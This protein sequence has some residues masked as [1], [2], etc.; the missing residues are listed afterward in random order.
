MERI[1]VKK[2]ASVTYTASVQTGKKQGSRLAPPIIK[3]VLAIMCCM[4]AYFTFLTAV[5]LGISLTRTAAV[6]ISVCVLC[7][8]AFSLRGKYLAA[9]SVPVLSALLIWTYF[10]RYE[11]CAGLF[12]TVN[13]YASMIHSDYAETPFMYITEPELAESHMQIFMYFITMVSSAAA[14]YSAQRLNSAEVMLLSVFTPVFLTL[15]YGMEPNNIAVF[16]F[17]AGWTAM[18]ALEANFPGKDGEECRKSS[19]AFCGLYTG[20]ACAVCIA[21]VLLAYKSF[22]YKRPEPLNVLYD[23]AVAFLYG[24]GAQETLDK[25]VSDVKRIVVTTGATDHGKLGELDEISFDGRTMLEVTLPKSEDTVYLR[26]FVGSVYTGK[27]WEPFPEA[28]E[29]ELDEMSAAYG[30]E[31]VSPLLLD[32]YSLKYARSPMPKYSFSVKSSESDS[33]YIYMP[34]NLVPESVSRY[35]AVDGSRFDGED[36]FYIG[37]FYDPR[38]YYDYQNLLRKRWSVSSSL[39]EYEAAYRQFVRENYLELPES[40]QPDDIFDES[41]YSYISAE[42]EATGKS[43]LDEM[44]VFSRKLYYIKKWLRDN[45]EYSLS[46]G[47]LPAGEDFVDRFLKQKK[48][49]CSHFASAA[50]LMCRYTGIP[51]RYAEGYVIK[52]ADFPSDAEVG[53]AVTVEVSDARGHAWVEVYI[54][55]FGWYPMEFTSGYGNIRTAITTA[56]EATE[57]ETESVTE[58]VTETVT[59]A[60]TTTAETAPQPAESVDEQN[61]GNDVSGQTVSETAPPDNVTSV[62]AERESMPVSESETAAE[63]SIGFGAFGI[64]GGRKVDIYYDLTWLIVAAAVIVLIP[65]VFIARRNFITARRRRIA[66]RSA[67]AGTLEEYRRFGKLMKL[68]NMPEQGEMSYSE[69]A[70]ALAKGSEMLADGTAEAVIG[71]ALKASFGGGSVTRADEGE[72]RFAVNSLAKRFCGTLSRFGKFKLKFLYCIL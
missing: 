24:G 47:K 68:M 60:E 7:S 69:Y 32:G 70:E 16:S 62:G 57:T 14:A 67:A 56:T 52:P 12:N 72:M 2:A 38:S 9:A 17:A 46:A 23:D 11:I 29:S 59:A 21:A 25:I 35:K 66:I 22:G 39:S 51:A 44:T 41:Y 71:Y 55:G 42:W 3:A 18:L 54:D 15:L 61:N 4:G 8:A 6:I 65:V 30:A 34:Y 33:G 58:Q 5:D 19:G 64:K 36:S 48:G 50:A 43:T 31:G 13:V 10:N 27:S 49:S 20:I 53:E 40:F 26:G 37:Q 1:N 45:C 28:A 63:P